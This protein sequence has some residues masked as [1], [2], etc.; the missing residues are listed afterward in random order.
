MKGVPKKGKY[1]KRQK[2]ANVACLKSIKNIVPTKI[3]VNIPDES[4]MSKIH[5]MLKNFENL[6]NIEALETFE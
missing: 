6:K 1:Q 3:F 2:I 5:K 4:V